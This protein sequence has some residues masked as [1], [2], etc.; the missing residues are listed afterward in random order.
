MKTNDLKEKIGEYGRDVR[1]NLSAILTPEGAPGLSTA[2]IWMTALACSYYTKDHDLVAAIAGDAGE[3]LSPE[4]RA[5]AKSAAAIMAMNNIYYRFTHLLEDKEISKMPARLRMSVIGK[6]GV[7]KVD[8]ELMCLAV[9]AMAG[10]G[11][12][13]NSHV[14][15]VKKAG[16]SNEAV[17]SS[18]R[19]AAI[20]NSVAQSLEIERAG[21]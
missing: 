20:L 1:L 15:E 21:A 10:C 2:Q 9:S 11:A 12:C 4:A 14:H 13:I 8:F 5:A 7:E 6:P 17:Q 19:I 18:V 3:A 16:L